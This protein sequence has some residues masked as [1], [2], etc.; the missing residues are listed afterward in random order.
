[1]QLR[2]IDKYT[3]VIS[4]VVLGAMAL[5]AWVNLHALR[6]HLLAEAVRDVDAL[7]E[8]IIQTTHYQMLE[9]DRTRV[10]EMIRE[11]GAQQGIEH[12]RLINKDGIISYSTQP[13]EIGSTV[14]KKA[15]ACTV[16]H[17]DGTPLVEA[18]SMHRSRFFTDAAGHEVLGIARGINNEAVCSSAACHVH[19]PRSKLLGVLDVTVSLAAMHQSLAQYRDR[20]ALWT[21]GLLA[22]MALVLTLL[23]QRL[24][25]APVQRLLRHTEQVAGGD[26]ASRIAWRSGDEL[27]QLALEFN[28]MTAHL[29]DTQRDLHELMHS[30]EAKVEERTAEI[31]RIESQLMQSEKLA[32]LGELVAGIAHEINNPLTGIVMFVSLSLERPELSEDLRADLQTVLGESRRCADIVHHLLDFSRTSQPHLERRSVVALLEQSLELLRYQALFLNIE[33]IRAFPENVPEILLDPQQIQQVFMN[34]LL[35]AAQAMPGGGVLTLQVVEEAKWLSIAVG[36]S[37]VGIL[38]E[39]LQKIFDPFYTTKEHTGTG[40]GL[41]VSYGIVQNHGGTI[42]VE[43]RLGEGTVFHVRLPRG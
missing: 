21:F 17:A 26:F 6:T 37:G 28:R 14:D 41:S 23:T 42:E 5:F 38:P 25:N 16:C 40:L 43:S 18:S 31:R 33:V 24:I 11:V 3:I 9:D 19:S 2:L 10:Y 35:N 12:I 8:T 13:W 1:M 32:S 29:E 4:L 22:I 30:L 20:M 34:I 36:D 27:G 7:S 39:N 15:E